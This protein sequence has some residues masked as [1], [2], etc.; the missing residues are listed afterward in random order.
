MWIKGELARPNKRG[1]YLILDDPD[2]D[3]TCFPDVCTYYHE[4]DVL[5]HLPLDAKT[6]EER[7]KQAL[8]D[9]RYHVKAPKDGFYMTDGEYKYWEVYPS[10]WC[11]LPAPP[12]GI[13]Y[14]DQEE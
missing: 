9:E 4:G 12:D 10:Y 2:S 8:F 1:T 14:A 3:G 6:P 7:L 11:P 5:L 13:T